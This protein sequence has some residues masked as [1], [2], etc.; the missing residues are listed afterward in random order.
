MIKSRTLM[1]FS[2]ISGPNSQ[3]IDVFSFSCQGHFKASFKEQ[4]VREAELRAQKM[5]IRHE[6]ERSKEEIEKLQVCPD[7]GET[8]WIGQN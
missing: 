4:A 2:D 8:V 1:L 7:S 3:F 5:Q 6:Q